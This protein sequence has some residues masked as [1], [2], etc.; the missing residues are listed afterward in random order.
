MFGQEH[1]LEKDLNEDE[2]TCQHC[3][4]YYSSRFRTNT[5][6]VHMEPTTRIET[7]VFHVGF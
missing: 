6:T 5:A 4:L 7:V 3:K 2:D 1:L